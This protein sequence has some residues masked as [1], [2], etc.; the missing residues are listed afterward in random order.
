MSTQSEGQI[1]SYSLAA[2][3]GSAVV[4]MTLLLLYI[5]VLRPLIDLLCLPYTCL[6][7]PPNLTYSEAEDKFRNEWVP[8]CVTVAVVRRGNKREAAWLKR[9]ARRQVAPLAPV[10]TL[11]DLEAVPYV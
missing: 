1:I 3:F 6:F 5:F 8:F 11:S 9:K 2:L 4:P 7:W 10:A